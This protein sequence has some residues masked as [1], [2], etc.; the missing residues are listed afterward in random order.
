MPTCM[1]ILKV[2]LQEEVTQSEECLLL[3]YGA[4]NFLLLH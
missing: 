2:K 1:E 4:K 3:A